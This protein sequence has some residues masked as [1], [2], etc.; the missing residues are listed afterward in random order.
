MESHVEIFWIQVSSRNSQNF[1]EQ[2]GKFSAWFIGAHISGVININGIVQ[3]DNIFRKLSIKLDREG[4]TTEKLIPKIN[5]TFYI[6]ILNNYFIL[7]KK[8][9]IKIIHNYINIINYNF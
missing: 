6:N 2:T 4:E 5:L 3:S 9:N 7:L 8:K 1:E